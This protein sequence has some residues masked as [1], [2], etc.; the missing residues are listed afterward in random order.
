MD[1][2]ARIA[3]VKTTN[4]ATMNL[5]VNF[6]VPLLMVRAAHIAQVEIIAM[7]MAISADGVAQARLGP[8]VLIAPVETTSDSN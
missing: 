8:P 5:D 7:G 1:P 6:V 2:D 4:T 3:Q